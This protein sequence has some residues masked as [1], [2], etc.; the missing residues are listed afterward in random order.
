MPKTGKRYTFTRNHGNGPGQI[1]AGTVAELVEVVPADTPGAGNDRDDA[2]VLVF[3]EP[4]VVFDDDNLP[5]IGAT[6]RRWAADE[7][8]FTPNDEGTLLEE[9]K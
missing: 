7:S 2:Y 9:D 1:R 3:E 4:T 8:A 5:Q 6:E